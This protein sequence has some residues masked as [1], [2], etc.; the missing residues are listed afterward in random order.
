MWIYGLIWGIFIRYLK[1]LPKSTFSCQKYEENNWNI[2]YLA[3]EVPRVAQ[4]PSFGNWSLLRSF[5]NFLTYFKNAP[6]SKN[7]K[8]HF[9]LLVF[10]AQTMNRK[11]EREPTPIWSSEWVVGLSLLCIFY[12]FWRVYESRRVAKLDQERQLVERRVDPEEV[13]ISYSPLLDGWLQ[14]QPLDSNMPLMV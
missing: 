1:N 14:V 5:G 13:C 2:P 3:L 8:T 12:I 10:C 4:L 9:V 11:T 7:F 6:A